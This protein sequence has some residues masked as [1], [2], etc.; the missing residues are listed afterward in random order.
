MFPTKTQKILLDKHFGCT[1][2]IYNRFLEEKINQYKETNKSDSF[3]VQCKTLVAFKKQEEYEWLN[4]VSA[5]SL[6]QTLR[7]LDEAYNNFFKRNTNFPKFK[8]KK[9]KNSF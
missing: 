9:N 6:Q 8:S 7:H 3:Y 5:Q 4:E 2:W 1:R